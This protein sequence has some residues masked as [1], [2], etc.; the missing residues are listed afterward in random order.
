MIL[1][2]IIERYYKIIEKKNKQKELFNIS[3]VADDFADDL[4]FQRYSNILYDLFIRRR[5]SIIS[6]ILFI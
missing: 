2:K 6:Y 4:K 3:I 5:Y 1:K